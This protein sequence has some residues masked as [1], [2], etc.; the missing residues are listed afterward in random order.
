MKFQIFEMAISAKRLARFVAACNGN[1]R[2]ALLLYKTNIRA[3][4]ALFSVLSIFEIVLRNEIDTHYRKRF[5]LQNN[6]NDEWL[7]AETQNRGFLNS[8]YC[9]NSVKKISETINE[10]NKQ[11]KYT[12]DKTV[13]ELTFGFWRFMFAGRQFQAGGSTL[14][15]ILKNRPKG[16]NHTDVYNRLT[17]INDIRNRIAHHEPICFGIGNTIS[18]NYLSRKYLLIIE[19]LDWLGYDTSILNGIDKVQTQISVLDTI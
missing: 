1:Q 4:Q 3:S 13:A 11:K 9:Q 8:I 19:V 10:L 6:G 18:S 17:E 16:V 2:K 5:A 7:L 14:L 12:H 15:T